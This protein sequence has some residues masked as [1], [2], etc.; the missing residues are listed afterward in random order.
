[1]YKI[2]AQII[3]LFQKLIT[4]FKLLLATDKYKTV[5]SALLFNLDDDDND[6]NNKEEDSMLTL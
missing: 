1:M 6:S 4:Y 2:A 5:I 3:F